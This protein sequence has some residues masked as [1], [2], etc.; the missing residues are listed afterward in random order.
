MRLLGSAECGEEGGS[1]GVKCG[2]TICP[3][4]ERRG[5]QCGEGKGRWDLDLHSE[6]YDGLNTL[7]WVNT[8]YHDHGVYRGWF[9]VLDSANDASC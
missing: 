1:L 5:G 3:E 9:I 2:E 7:E 6:K 4:S 8:S